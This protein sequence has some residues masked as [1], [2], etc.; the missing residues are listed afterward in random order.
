MIVVL[1]LP[2]AADACVWRG[3][4]L[5]ASA[6]PAVSRHP[7]A[8]WLAPERRPWVARLVG[9]TAQREFV[10]GRRDYRTDPP[11]LC[12]ELRPGVYEV[13]AMGPVLRPERD[14]RYFV[15]SAGG[16]LAE[17]DAATA[18]REAAGG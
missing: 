11:T 18:R 8:R 14:R 2:A 9:A 7:A 6:D 1:Q 10:R 5:V 3:G 13:F 4:R 15:R 16:A 17:I 12:Y